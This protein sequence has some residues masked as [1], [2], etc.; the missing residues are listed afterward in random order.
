MGFCHAVGG[1]VTGDLSIGW[2]VP[3]AAVVVKVYRFRHLS[4]DLQHRGTGRGG[5]K[6]KGRLVSEGGVQAA[7]AGGCSS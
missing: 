2:V 5:W 3:D 4:L 7:R 6:Q 1:L